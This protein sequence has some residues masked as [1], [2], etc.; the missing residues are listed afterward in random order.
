MDMIRKWKD[1]KGET[2]SKFKEM[3]EDYRLNKMLEDRQKSANERELEKHMKDK[4]EAEI[5]AQLDVIRRDKS[6]EL[7]KGGMLKEK[8]TI[9]QN[10]RPILKEKNIFM[11]KR[12]DIPF[13]KHAGGMFFK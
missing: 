4:R 10:G 13:V 11:D 1:R 8:T 5:K 2:S 6:K 3:Q 12:N 9:L 7:W